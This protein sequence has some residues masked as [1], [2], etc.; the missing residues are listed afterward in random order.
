MSPKVTI[1]IPTYRRPKSLRRAILSTLT[2][3][4]PDFEVRVC[5]DASGDETG[6]VTREMAARDS[7]VKYIDRVQNLGMVG[8]FAR[9]IEEVETPFFTVLDDDD[10]MMPDFLA[11]GLD[12]LK[13]YD[14]A[15]IYC[16]LLVLCSEDGDC[17]GAPEVPAAG[18]LHWPP[19]LLKMMRR[20]SLGGVIFRTDGLRRAGGLDPEIN[21]SFDTD[22]LWRIA[23]CWPIALGAEPGILHFVYEASVGNTLRAE[24]SLKTLRQMYE[25]TRAGRLDC[26]AEAA[27]ELREVISGSYARQ[28]LQA[29]Q[30]GELEAA[31]TAAGVLRQ[32][33]DRRLSGLCLE[34]IAASS[35]LSRTLAGFIRGGRDWQESRR[36]RKYRH[37]NQLIKR[38][39]E[40]LT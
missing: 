5:D 1:L 33:M 3:S 23:A 38:T 16:G 15:S 26:S 14:Q 19:A 7:R 35:L 36:R 8:N 24:T 39:L 25:K 22:I 18:G 21:F 32:E 4:V 17:L 34:A 12:A 20:Q 40:A 29:I 30:N 37:Y 9:S 28:A 31:A 6:A 10:V 27:A 13:R 11:A 2:Q